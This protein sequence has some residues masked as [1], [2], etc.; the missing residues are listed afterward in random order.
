[1][2]VYYKNYRVVDAD[3]GDVTVMDPWRPNRVLY[4]TDSMADA[5]SFVRAYRDGQYWA[6]KAANN[7]VAKQGA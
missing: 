6:V 7:S 5:K 4:L 3:C 1:M 2:V